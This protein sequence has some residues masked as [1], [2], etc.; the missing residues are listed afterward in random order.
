MS[1]RLSAMI[2]PSTSSTTDRVLEYGALN[3]ATPASAAAA[4]SIWLVPMQNAPIASRLLWARTLAL[5]WVLERMPSRETPSRASISSF[6]SSAP[7]RVSTSYPASVRISVARGWMFSSSRARDTAAFSA[8]GRG[9]PK[10]VSEP[11]A[12]P[13]AGRARTRLAGAPDR[14]PAR[15]RQAAS[16]R[17]IASR[18]SPLGSSP[19]KPSRRVALVIAT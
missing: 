17:A 1:R 12:K 8:L 11:I 7:F 2:S 9:R 4:R 19:R 13:P 18:S 14:H 15:T 10:S 6:S 3:A 16:D 5:T